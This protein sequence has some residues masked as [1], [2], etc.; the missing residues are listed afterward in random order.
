MRSKKSEAMWSDLIVI[1][2]A[3]L[4]LYMRVDCQ[5]IDKGTIESDNVVKMMRAKGASRLELMI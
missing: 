2:G 5:K 3:G 4:I 1:E